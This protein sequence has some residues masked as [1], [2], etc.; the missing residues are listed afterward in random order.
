[1]FVKICGITRLE[2]A[3]AAVASGADAL[4]FVCWPQSPRFVPVERVRDIVSAL[5][6]TVVCVGVFPDEEAR[7]T[8]VVGVDEADEEPI[9]FRCR[10]PGAGVWR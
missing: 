3:E 7:A 8:D 5:P 2:D 1:M 9:A 6:A 4:G 10:R